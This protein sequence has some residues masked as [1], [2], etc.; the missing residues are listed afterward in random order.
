MKLKNNTYIFSL[1]SAFIFFNSCVSLT[2]LQSGRTL[3]KNNAEIGVHYVDG[4]YSQILDN[5][6]DYIPVIGLKIQLGLSENFD[7]GFSAD[8]TSMISTHFKYQFLG[9]K[10]SLFAVSGGFETGFNFAGFLGGL[11]INYLTV[12]LYSSFHPHKY[13]ALY[14]SPRYIFATGYQFASQSKD[15]MGLTDRANL[16]GNS[17]GLSLGNH[18]KVLFEIQHFDKVILKPTGFAIGYR[19]QF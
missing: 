19:F 1:L 12:P 2:T 15:P 5:D 13:F 18:H 9:N 14:Y 6:E 3:G 4:K 7:I 11:S 17:Y 10:T 8:Y 16:F